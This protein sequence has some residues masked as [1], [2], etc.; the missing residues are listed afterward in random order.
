MSTLEPPWL[1]RFSFDS[2]RNHDGLHLELRGVSSVVC[3][4]NT[5]VMKASLNT[6]FLPIPRFTHYYNYLFSLANFSSRP[7]SAP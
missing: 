1:Y 7:G 6:V 2:V 4:R 5:Y 3:S